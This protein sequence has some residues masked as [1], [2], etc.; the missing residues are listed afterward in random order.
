MS[1][2]AVFIFVI[3]FTI[4][5][6]SFAGRTYYI[7]HIN[8]SLG[9]P[10]LY[11]PADNGV[12]PSWNRPM[13]PIVYYLDSKF[14]KLS[15]GIEACNSAF[16]EWSKVSDTS[17]FLSYG[18][19][20]S[21]SGDWR[22]RMANRDYMD[23]VEL[24]KENWIA[25]EELFAITNI[26]YNVYTGEIWEADI[27]LNAQDYKWARRSSGE[28]SNIVDI[29]NILSHEIGHFIGIGHSQ[30]RLATMYPFSSASETRKRTL[31][32]DDKEA[33][34]YLYPANSSTTFSPS[35]WRLVSG[36]CSWNW[37]YSQGGAELFEN[38]GVQRVCV[39]GD[40]F[41]EGISLK[42]ISSDGSKFFTKPIVSLERLSDNLIELEVNV[43]QLCVDSYQ[44]ELTTPQGRSARLSQALFLNKAGNTLPNARGR[45]SSTEVEIGKAFT[46]D[47]SASYDQDGQILSYKW[48]LL[49][50]AGD[51]KIFSPDLAQT[52]AK[53]KKP[54][55]Y[56]FELVVSDGILNGPR[57]LV[58]VS[59]YETEEEDDG[60][61]DFFGCELS[62][63][64]FLYPEDLYFGFG[65]IIIPLIFLF[66][67]KRVQ[68]DK[69]ARKDDKQP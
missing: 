49:E 65:L 42:F 7:K 61:S 3:L 20:V 36:Q 25:G 51:A 24:V 27:F 37:D 6:F 53:L 9:E 69:Y 64:G 60:N 63:T 44:I 1:V 13:K 52:E 58:L 59:G 56:L 35:P 50:G 43:D 57:D 67:L 10:E 41:S 22:V 30:M 62:R 8:D 31:H 26:F 32:P 28:G 68:G 29:Q 16:E 66:F 46:L 11:R 45:S 55:D 21:F 18:G 12:K 40:G 38:S 54:G 5:F 15:Y 17:V 33:L 19:T 47:G 14:L 2:R 23:S 48:S 34:R 39:Y 4:I